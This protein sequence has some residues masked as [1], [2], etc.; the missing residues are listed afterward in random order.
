[1]L[2]ATAASAQSTNGLVLLTQE[3]VS[4][5][6]ERIGGGNPMVAQTTIGQPVGERVTNGVV[7]I[8][9]GPMGTSSRF[10]NP[11]AAVTIQGTL[12]E[13]V[14][15]LRLAAN[16]ADVPVTVSGLSFTAANV[17]LPFGPNVLTATATD[18]SGNTGTASITVLV[19]LP[20]ESK[21][22]A[23]VAATEVRVSCDDPGAAVTVNGTA[24]TCA[25]G[26]CT[27][28]AVPLTQGLNRLTAR[29]TDAASN[30]AEVSIDVFVDTGLPT[31]PEVGTYSNPLPAVT[32]QTSITLHGTK[33]AG[34]AIWIN[35]ALAV[36]ADGATAW[37]AG[38]A[39]VE[40]DNILIVTAR[41][42]AGNDSAPMRV[43]VVLDREPPVITADSVKTNFNPY[44]FSGSVDDSLTRVLINGQPAQS[45]GRVFQA[46]LQL[47]EGPNPVAI[48]ATS[49][50]GYVATKDLTVTLGTIPTIGTLQ[51]QDG[52]L[53][54]LSAPITIQIGAT[55]K[56]GDPT[57]HRIL[58]DAT[59]VRDWDA[60]PSHTWTPAG[61]GL[62]ALRGE[63]RDDFGGSNGVD[64]EVFVVRPPVDHP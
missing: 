18:P 62:H 13:T 40:G 55:D 16:G 24:A 31:R 15:T 60:Q 57:Q 38:V 14:Q 37:S 33:A 21:A 2:T 56:E 6:G 30:S 58:L 19:D 54:Y 48:T 3:T 49:H 22:A 29:A 27:A 47:V 61:V 43:T 4:S 64:H 17:P 10:P 25:G 34:A 20:A 35:G 28:P 53:P 8:V 46:T 44:A 5:G 1:L 63:V 50:F 26:L 11:T 32:A 42:L 7:T 12:S 51:P 41:D 39:L 52:T 59:V 36:P 9:S 45:S 23:P